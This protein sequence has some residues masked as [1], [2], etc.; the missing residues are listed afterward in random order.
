MSYAVQFNFYLYAVGDNLNVA[1]LEPL[2]ARP[3]QRSMVSTAWL[4]PS[5]RFWGPDEVLVSRPQRNYTVKNLKQFFT[6]LN[7]TDSYEMYLDTKDLIRDLTPPGVEVHCLHGMNVSTPGQL[8]YGPNTWPDTQP[9]V[10]PDNGDG[11]VNIRSLIAC[12]KW[13]GKQKQKVYHT[14]FPGAEHMEVL[15]DPRIKA[16]LKS[17]LVS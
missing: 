11:T 13:I 5:D 2:K 9:K 4:T 6:D 8:V 3:Q 14:Q 17:L 15:H 12:S 1:V 10:I 16:Y 7:L